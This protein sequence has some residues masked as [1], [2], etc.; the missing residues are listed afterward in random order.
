MHWEL[1][2]RARAVDNQI[3]VATCSPARNSKQ[4][5]DDEC[6]VKCDYEAYGFSLVVNPL[7][8]VVGKCAHG[9]STLVMDLDINEANT[10][11][12]N[13]PLEKQRRHD[14]YTVRYAEN[15]GDDGV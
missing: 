10:F 3:F 11:R 9:V 7:G 8:A 15:A 5:D 4:D 14:L 2:Q 13:V 6:E 12:T 1:L